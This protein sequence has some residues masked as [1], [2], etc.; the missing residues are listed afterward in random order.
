MPKDQGVANFTAATIS[1][2][3]KPHNATLVDEAA[4]DGRGSVDRDGRSK[5]SRGEK[6]LGKGVR[7]LP[8]QINKDL[9]R[10][11][12]IPLS[13]PLDAGRWKLDALVERERSRRRQAAEQTNMSLLIVSDLG[14]G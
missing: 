6:A 12:K 13:S 2:A 14:F 5:R 7:T 8:A 9:P 10:Q 3:V 1:D 4:P 11:N